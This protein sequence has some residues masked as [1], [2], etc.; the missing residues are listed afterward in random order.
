MQSSGL[1]LLF[2]GGS[3]SCGAVAVYSVG[4]RS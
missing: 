3:C 4:Y 1:V 2:V